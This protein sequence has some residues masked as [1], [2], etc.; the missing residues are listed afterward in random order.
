MRFVE[1]I[2]IGAVFGLSEILPISA[3]GHMAILL[4]LMRT[5]KPG[6]LYFALAYPALAAAVGISCRQELAALFGA[7]GR[8]GARDPRSRRMLWFLVLGSLPLALAPLLWSA[9]SSLYGNLL[10]VSIAMLVSGVVLFTAERLGGGDNDDRTMTLADALFTGAGQL[11]SVL[12]GLSRMGFA[13]AVPL[14]RQ[15]LASSLKYA[16]LLSVPALL[17]ASVVSFFEAASMQIVWAD[18]PS[19]LA[20]AV[21]AGLAAF[22]AVKLLNAIAR[23]GSLFGFA[24][25][26]WGAGL[27]ALFLSL[28]S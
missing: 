7:V 2:I 10:F 15:Q 17:G 28:I 26:T 14:V 3:S 22:G 25:Y 6:A 18:L 23:K 5:A 24:Y 27:I 12:P 11:V 4:S 20:G 19:A 21:A 1:A 16:L 8:G 9:V 13:I